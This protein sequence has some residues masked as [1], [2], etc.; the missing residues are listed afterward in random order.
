[1]PPDLTPD[2]VQAVQ[3]V[4]SAV[5]RD[6]LIAAAGGSIMSLL[7]LGETFTWKAAATAIVSGLFAAYYGVELV[8]G[9]FNLGPGY[10]GALGAGFGLGSMTILG[11]VFKLLRSWRDDPSGFIQ[12]F[13]P[14]LRKGGEQ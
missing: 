11:G 1:M 6:I 7:F 4:I 2:T 8:A 12:R 10:Y 5:Q 13:I 14:F 3:P 9:A